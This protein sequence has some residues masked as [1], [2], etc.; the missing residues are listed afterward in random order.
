[1]NGLALK[2]ISEI[3]ISQTKRYNDYKLKCTKTGQHIVYNK[4]Y[5]RKML[6]DIRIAKRKGAV[7]LG[8]FSCN[9]SRNFVATKAAQKLLSVKYSGK[10]MSRNFLPPQLLREIGVGSTFCNDP[11]NAA[12]NLSSV[13]Y[14]GV[15]LGNVS[16]NVYATM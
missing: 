9:L 15:T 3:F 2:E 16:C 7:T 8:N 5:H 14:R 12:T 11:R 13:A 10:N 6:F 4:Q 1:M